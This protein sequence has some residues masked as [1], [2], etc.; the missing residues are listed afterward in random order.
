MDGGQIFSGD[1]KKYSFNIFNYLDVKRDI[2]N[3]SE[4][5]KDLHSYNNEN[6]KKKNDKKEK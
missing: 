4:I 2:C 3:H 5:Y 6:N 1:E